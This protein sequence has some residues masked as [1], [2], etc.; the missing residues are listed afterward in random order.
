[1]L[2]LVVIRHVVFTLKCS[3]WILTVSS[4][5]DQSGSRADSLHLY[6]STHGTEQQQPT[7][8]PPIL[9]VTFRGKWPLSDYGRDN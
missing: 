9:K 3:L 8:E 4:V 5:A 6:D 1:M 7:F 2:T